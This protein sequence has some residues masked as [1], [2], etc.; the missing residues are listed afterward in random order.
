[1]KQPIRK[2]IN[3]LNNKTKKQKSK[4]KTINDNTILDGSGLETYFKENFLD[5][6]EINYTQQFEAKDIGRFYDFHLKDKNNNSL[7]ILVEIDGTYWHTDPRVY[8][9]PINPIQKRN[10]RV[11]EIKNKWALLH[12]FCLI[13][14][15]EYDIKNNP[16]KIINE[17]KKH[18]SIQTEKIFLM[19]SKKNGTFYN[20][21]NK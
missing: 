16:E 2:K 20:K 10:K 15:W 18:M 8:D 11:D 9:K 19:E 14:L 17:L 12:G 4:N 7:R 13:R 5:K 21:K 6:L 1:M 3:N